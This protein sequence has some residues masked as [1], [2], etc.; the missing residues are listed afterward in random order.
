LRQFPSWP[1]E[2]CL[3]KERSHEEAIKSPEICTKASDIA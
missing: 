1:D 2:H 3:C